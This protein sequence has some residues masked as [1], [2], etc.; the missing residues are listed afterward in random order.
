MKQTAWL[1]SDLDSRLDAPK[2]EG[3]AGQLRQLEGF[4]RLLGLGIRT[5]D[6]NH[7]T[8]LTQDEQPVFILGKNIEKVN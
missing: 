3:S 5:L 6:L 8:S 4:V 1:S 2:P 7:M